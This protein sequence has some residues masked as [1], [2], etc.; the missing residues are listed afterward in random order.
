MSM[1]KALLSKLVNMKSINR[2]AYNK[3]EQYVTQSIN[4]APPS[5][6]ILAAKQLRRIVPRG[7]KKSGPPSSIDTA[8]MWADPMSIVSD[9]ITH[10]CRPNSSD[11][12][13]IWLLGVC[14]SGFSAE[15][16]ATLKEPTPRESSL[17]TLR[18]EPVPG[19]LP[20]SVRLAIR[21]VR[22]A[23]MCLDMNRSQADGPPICN[24]IIRSHNELSQVRLY[25][26]MQDTYND[27]RSF[28]DE[29]G[30]LR[31]P[32]KQE[33][34]QLWGQRGCAQYSLTSVAKAGQAL[35]DRGYLRVVVNEE[36]SDPFEQM[37]DEL[38]EYTDCEGGGR[39]LDM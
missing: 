39:D 28:F 20:S 4:Q 9:C 7:K 32:L 35:L 16:W 14:L 5:A 18:A 12:S 24:G 2:G 29:S 15:S 6:Q 11:L 8:R 17:I 13:P 38:C 30:K 34:V 31:T 21:F 3:L 10:I 27:T 36:C 23:L 1:R 19:I 37:W 22:L 33:Y 26:S 25:N